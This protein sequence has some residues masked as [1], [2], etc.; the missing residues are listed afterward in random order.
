MTEIKSELIVDYMGSTG[1]HL[2]II[3]LA[4]NIKKLYVINYDI[5]LNLYSINKKINL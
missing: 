1:L 3:K 2:F 4:L 5:W